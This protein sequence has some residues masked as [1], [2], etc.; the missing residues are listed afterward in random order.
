VVIIP[1]IKQEIPELITEIIIHSNPETGEVYRHDTKLKRSNTLQEKKNRHKHA[2]KDRLDKEFRIYQQEICGYFVFFMLDN[3]DVL[4]FKLDNRELMSFLYMGTFVKRG[5]ALKLDNNKTYISKTTLKK[6]LKLDKNKFCSFYNKLIKN[7]FMTEDEYGDRLHINILYFYRGK[8]V[9]YLKEA[10]TKNMENYSRV[11]IESLR[12][13]YE[14]STVSQLKKIANFYKLLPYV[15]IKYNVLCTDPKETNELLIQALDTKQICSILGYNLNQKAR[16]IK[17]LLA[18]KY[19][20]YDIFA[21]ITRNKG[22]LFVINPLVF[23][24]GYDIQELKYLTTLFKIKP[25][26]R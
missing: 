2:E 11:Y 6:I 16:L 10:K 8:K 3:I 17:E 25:L 1:T 19:K 9:N 7:N 22:I 20:K 24:K 18:L 12:H 13:L 26:K 15:N 14:T 5:G 23:Y 21:T 4:S